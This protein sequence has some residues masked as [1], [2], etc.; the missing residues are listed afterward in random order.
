MLGA[1]LQL[2]VWTA[3]CG[4]VDQSG[5]YRAPTT[6][7]GPCV[8]SAERNDTVWSATVRLLASD[9]LLTFPAGMSQW[10]ASEYCGQAGLTGA[11]QPLEPK[12]ALPRVQLAAQC[13]VRLFIVPPRHNLTANGKTAGLFVIDSAKVLTDRYAAVLPT[14]TLAK[15][16]STILGLNLGDDY[17]D[18]NAWGGQTITN[19]QIAAWAAYASGK[20][21][22]M[23]LGVR[24]PC[25]WV[26][27]T[28]APLLD[29]CWAQYRADFGDARTWYAT[30]AADAKADGLRIVAGVNLQNCYGPSTPG[31]S[32]ADLTT[33][34]TA[35]ISLPESCAFVSWVY[36][37]AWWADP[38]VRLAFGGLLT[39]AKQ[40]TGTDCRRIRP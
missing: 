1:L 33:F 23:P 28:L 13:G 12:D 17:G 3:T 26:G 24:V 27:S 9:V 40:R 5:V 15:Y 31:C 20:L 35:A 36:D 37:P 14:D 32:A 4:T 21:I 10:P 18:K 19:T 11:M 29:Y 2:A 30:Q 38:N 6:G 16:R 22:G 8:V 34:G 25:R 7:T 39:L